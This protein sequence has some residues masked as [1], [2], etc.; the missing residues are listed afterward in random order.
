VSGKYYKIDIRDTGVGIDKDKL[1]HIFEPFY[2]T[3]GEGTGLGLFMVYNTIKEMGGFITVDS[4]PGE[5][6]CFSL[7]IPV[8]AE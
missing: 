3:K 7:Y 2:T 4:V 8:L 5:G 6:T 1:E